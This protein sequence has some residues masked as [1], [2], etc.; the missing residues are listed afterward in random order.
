MRVEVGELSLIFSLIFFN[1]AQGLTLAT[2]P[3]MSFPH[4][5]PGSVART[6]LGKCETHTDNKCP[7]QM[8]R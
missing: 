2:S 3:H 6:Q 7:G 4:M 1:L 5:I 8:V